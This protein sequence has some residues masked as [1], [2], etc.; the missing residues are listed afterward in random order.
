MRALIYTRVSQD[1]AG[2]RSPAEQ[3]TEARAVCAREGWQVAEVVTDSAGAS[4]HSKGHRDG[5]ARARKMV[6]DRAADV[7]VTWEASRAQRDLAAYAELRQLCATAGVLWN[8]SGRTYDMSESGDRFTTG[9]DALLAEREADETAGRVQRA[10]RANAV[11]GRP[12]GRRLF[13]YQRVY[14]PTSGALVTQEPHPDEAG[15]VAGM[16]DTYLGGV[17][18]RTIARQ[19]NAAGVTT[20]TG[21]TWNDPQVRRVL[22]NPAYAARRVHRGEVVGAASWPALVDEER[23]DRVQVRLVASRTST[24]RATGSPKLLT[25]VGR[26]GLCGSKVAAIHDR[27]RR[28]V[29]VCRDRFHVGRD[30]LKLDAFVGAVVVERLERPDVAEALADAAPDDTAT[31]AR[32][33]AATLRAQLDTAVEEFTA[34]R[35][36]AATLGRV[37]AGLV[38]LIAEA[39]RQ[40]RRALVPLEVDVPAHGVRA[41]WD[42]LAD[43][44][45]RSVVG[46]LIAEVV[47]LPTKRGARSFDPDAVRVEW[48]SGEARAVDRALTAYDV[49]NPMGTL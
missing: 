26:C 2:G 24:T 40:A 6:G 12:H 19:L 42:G 36:T 15:T 39:E 17:G 3:E 45:R 48:R 30:M 5:W 37:E 9:L 22:I 1:R 49:V 13:G 35:L 7:L 38:P 18:I 20:G 11:S 25:G 23:F 28:K 32:A 4:R 14:D 16:F 44:V 8:Y 10:M 46:A 29:Y 47:I 31:V 27:N 41:W 33:R 43:E 34:G 21:A